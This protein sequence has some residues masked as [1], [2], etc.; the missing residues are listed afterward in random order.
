MKAPRTKSQETNKSQI[1]FE[2]INPE[3]EAGCNL[4]AQIKQL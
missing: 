3:A 2:A 4:N 1:K